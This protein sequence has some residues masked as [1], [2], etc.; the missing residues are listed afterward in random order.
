MLCG[1]KAQVSAR[2]ADSGGTAIRQRH[3]RLSDQQTSELIQRHRDGA[4]E[5][6]LAR[7]NGIHVETVRA[8]IR[9]TE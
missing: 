4:F 2:S 6:E 9:R 8:I 5:E 3:V 7:A 1:K